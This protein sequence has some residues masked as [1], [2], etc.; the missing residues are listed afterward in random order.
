VKSFCCDLQVD[1]HQS[2]ECLTRAIDIYTDMGRFSMAAKH[3]QT[4]A[5]L[6]ENEG[7]DLVSLVLRREKVQINNSF[8]DFLVALDS[9][10]NEL[11][12]TTNKQLTSSKEKRQQVRQTNAC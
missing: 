1:P 2:V 10:S 6:F 7:N 4:I 12:S 9:T 8:I 5:E 3:H 11:S